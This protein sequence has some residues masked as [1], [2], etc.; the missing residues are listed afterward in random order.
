MEQNLQTQEEKVKNNHNILVII[1]STLI[2]TFVVG[3]GTYFLLIKSTA[4]VSSLEVLQPSRAGNNGYVLSSTITNVSPLETLSFVYENNKFF[5]IQHTQSGE[6]KIALKSIG[7][8]FR[9]I[10]QNDEQSQKPEIYLFKNNNIILVEVVEDSGGLSPIVLHTL[11]AINTTD[12]TEQ[13]LYVVRESLGNGKEGVTAE[14]VLLSFF[15]K[16]DLILKCSPANISPNPSYRLLD[17]SNC[18]GVYFVENYS[19]REENLKGGTQYNYTYAENKG[20]IYYDKTGKV[21]APRILSEKQGQRA[22]IYTRFSDLIQGKVSI[23][24][25]FGEDV[26]TGGKNRQLFELMLYSN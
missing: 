25:G 19:K 7:D 18:N 15:D 3:F 26:P 2:T 21:I 20:Y 8:Y 14:P 9:V 12:K 10:F 24:I 5:L 22:I 16:N 4:T 17:F 1:V 23:A 11:F 6:N 13:K